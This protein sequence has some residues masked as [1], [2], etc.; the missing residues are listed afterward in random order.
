MKGSQIYWEER[1]KKSLMEEQQQ[2]IVKV[3]D[4]LTLEIIRLP[5]EGKAPRYYLTLW[6]GQ[7]GTL[8]IMRAVVDGS[9]TD[10]LR[11]WLEGKLTGRL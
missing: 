3:S 1:R 11:N 9:D 6:G 8:Q 10:A 5:R 7:F 4:D 2:A